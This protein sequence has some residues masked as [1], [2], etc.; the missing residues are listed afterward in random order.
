MGKLAR[1]YGVTLAALAEA[2]GVGPP[3]TIYVGQELRIPGRGAPAPVEQPPAIVQPAAVATEQKVARAP[4]A[5]QPAA[6]PSQQTAATPAVTRHVVQR[7][8]NLLAIAERFQVH[9]DDLAAANGLHPPYQ[10]LVGQALRIPG[11]AERRKLAPA[12]PQIAS[13]TTPERSPV[14]LGTPPPIGEEGFLWPVRGKVIEA[15]GQVD[16]GPRADGITIAARK[17]TPVL[18]AESGVVAF[19]GEGVRAH[20][21]MLLIRHDD[22]Y[23]TTYAHNAVLLVAEGDVVRRGQAIARVGSSGDATRSQLHFELRKG[24]K[25]IDPKRVLVSEPTAVASTQ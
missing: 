25:P 20:G 5:P 11:S 13:R 10:V 14:V 7:G 15:F 9:P 8:D 24:R 23:I 3:Y 21:L 19:A 2:N 1:A 16:D 18:A 6:A 12:S 4:V 22:D 17:G